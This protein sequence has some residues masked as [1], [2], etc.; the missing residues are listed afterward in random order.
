MIQTTFES[1]VDANSAIDIITGSSNSISPFERNLAARVVSKGEVHDLVT[2]IQIMLQT[3]SVA[4]DDILFVN[5]NGHFDENTQA[6]VEMIQKL[7]DLPQTGDVDLITWN[8]LSR[9]YNKY[10]DSEG[11]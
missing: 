4:T 6:A 1:L 7:N 9:L 5:V 10:A 3:I 8:R 11:I 2:I